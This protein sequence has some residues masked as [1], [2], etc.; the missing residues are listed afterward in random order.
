M[1]KTKFLYDA[2][3]I[4]TSVLNRED[5]R[6][7]LNT[8]PE[9]HSTLIDLFKEL[10]E[11]TKKE[12]DKEWEED[13]RYLILKILSRP[14]YSYF[15]SVVFVFENDINYYY[16]SKYSHNFSSGVL[17]IEYVTNRLFIELGEDVYQMKQ[18]N[19]SE[20]V[21]GKWRGRNWVLENTL[22]DLNF[23]NGMYLQI[24]ELSTFSTE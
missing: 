15:N 11:I 1:K 10:N 4:K 9:E 14:Y 3:D 12:S 17:Q 5:F 20:M 18:F 21:E 16:F 23:T 7:Y 22:I 6:L 8:L 19:S 24:R 13:G 2:Y